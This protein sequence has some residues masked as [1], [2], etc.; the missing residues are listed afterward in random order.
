VITAVLGVAVYAATRQPAHATRR[1][2]AGAHGVTA[3]PAPL[4][5]LSVSPAAGARAVNGAEPVQVRFSVPLAQDSPMPELAPAVRGR[6][7]RT[8]TATVSFTPATAFAPLTSVRVIIP[9]GRRG[10]RS[11]AGRLLPG[12][13]VAGFRTGTWQTLRFE[14]LLAQLGYL[15]LSW[16]PAGHGLAVG[17]AESPSP[18]NAAAQLSALYGPPAGTFSWQPGYPASLRRLWTAGKA[19]LILRGAVMAFESDH[20]LA[21]DGVIGPAAWQAMLRAAAVGQ[22]SA[23]GYTYALAS[24]ASPETLT[25]WHD[26]Q[27]VFR[28]A[29]NTGIPA[30]PTADGTYPV[31]L[32]YRFQIMRGVNPDGSH[33][34]DPVAFVA[35]FNGGDAVHYFPR[36]SYGSPQS[37]GCVEL[38]HAAAQRAWR[39][40][41]Y[42][43]LVTVTG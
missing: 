7:Q 19:G 38:P 42:G 3:P 34:A 43:S 1:G 31:Y 11:A 2:A 18:A 9:V 23:S 5:V 17:G 26:G 39:Y 20:R 33:Y 8:G 10:V 29:A 35:Y 21:M 25:I 37:L 30:A 14:Q 36:A 24:K 4:R 41:T 15:P 16:A 13:V 12:R 40:L 32:R 22:A 28:H 27:V 6:W